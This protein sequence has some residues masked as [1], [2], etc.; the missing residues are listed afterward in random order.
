MSDKIVVMKDGLKLQEGAPEDV[1][2][3][4]ANH[5]VA[6]F[7]GHSNFSSGTVRGKE[8]GLVWVELDSGNEIWAVDT[9]RF[10]PGDPVEVVVRAQRFEAYR[11]S[12]FNPTEKMNYYEGTIKDKSYMGGEVSYFIELSNGREIHVI[13][14]M[15][16]RTYD[17][18]D[19]VAVQ[20]APKHCHLIPKDTMT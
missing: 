10:E 18:G 17:Y 3:Y 19:D 4:P 14:M 6:D 12:E 15:R 16:T 8:D 13:S 20:V 5:F 1:Y 9:G 2:N 11:K 7:L